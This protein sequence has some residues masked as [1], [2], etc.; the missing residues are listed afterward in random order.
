MLSKR[1]LDAYPFHLNHEVGASRVSIQQEVGAQPRVLPGHGV[2]HVGDEIIKLGR[3]RAH[4]MESGDQR[5]AV[6][7]TGGEL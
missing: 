6:K 5:N 1:S 3:I 7:C 4:H 2:L